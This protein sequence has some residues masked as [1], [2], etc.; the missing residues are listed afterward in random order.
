M[1]STKKSD[2]SDLF[3]VRIVLFMISQNL[4]L[5]GSSVVGFA[6]IWYITLETSSGIWLMY[7]T[8]ANMV[9]HL[10]ISLYS[11]VWADRYRKKYLIMLSDGFIALVTLILFI[12]FRMGFQQLWLLLLVSVIRSLGSGVQGPAVSAILPQLVPS[13]HLTRIQGI[14][15]S[16]SS[17]LY[18][19]APAVGGMVFGLMDDSWNFLLHVL[20]ASLHLPVFICF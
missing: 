4:S 13:V 9:P 2:G 8:L 17:V 12:L 1:D 5:F 3:S 11:G 7:A 6:I 19:L 15:Q 18:M 10:F 20:T 16:I 14:N